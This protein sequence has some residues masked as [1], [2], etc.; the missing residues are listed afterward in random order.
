MPGERGGEGADGRDLL[1]RREDA[2]LELEGGEAV[3][4][5]EGPGLRDDARRVEGGAPVVPLRRHAVGVGGVLV[6]EVGAVLDG[7]AHLAAEQGV[8]GQAEGLAEGVQAGDLEGGEHGQA[9]LVGRLHAA[10]PADVDLAKDAG[11]V[12][13]DPV[14]VGEQA[15]QVADRAADQGVREGAGQFQVLGVA[16]GLAQSGGAVG[17]HHLDDQAGGVGLVDALGVEQGRVGDEDRRQ[18]DLRHGQVAGRR[19]G[20]RAAPTRSSPAASTALRS[21]R[22][23]AEGSVSGART[24]P[25]GC[26]RSRAAAFTSDTAYPGTRSRSSTNGT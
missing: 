10:Q 12:D 25:T 20:H 9:Q 2:A 19:C 6:E 5:L 8:H 16:V 22:S 11:G 15:V 3:P 1:V 26:P 18:P 24:G 13:G 7:V 17:G 14:R 4:L 21:A 23:A